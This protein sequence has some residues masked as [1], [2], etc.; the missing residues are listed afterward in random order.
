MLGELEAGHELHIFAGKQGPLK[1]VH[2]E[3]HRLNLLKQ[4]TF[5][6]PC[7]GLRSLH[8]AIQHP[9]AFA[10]SARYGR[11]CSLSRLLPALASCRELRNFDIIHAHFGTNGLKAVAL[12]ELG[13]TQGKIITTFYGQDVT[14]YPRK[15]GSDCYR[16]LFAQ[17]DWFLGISQHLVDLVCRLGCNPAKISKLHIGVQSTDFD[18]RPRTI[19]PGEP[20]RLLTVARLTEKKGLEYAIRAVARIKKQSPALEYRILGEGPLRGQLERL[21]RQLG[22]E[23][24]IQLSGAV[25]HDQVR[26]ACA[27][28][29]LFILPS[30]T[31]R[32]GDQ[33]GQALV[34]QEAQASGLPVLAT[35]HDGIPEGVLD[36]QS[37]FLVPER[38]VDALAERLSFLLTHPG[39]W[40]EMGKAGHRFVGEKFDNAQLTKCLLN[41]YHDLL[42][43]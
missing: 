6:P 1:S 32:N 3:I 23:K 20:I 21:V 5:P 33:E 4:T 17:G 24:H 22:M 25:P 13:I 43:H 8:A 14:H 28:A 38:D 15:H 12:R 10:I 11:A 30:V 37:G 26:T 29:H 36:G 35:R 19:G 9:G 27:H 42:G 40:P 39:L 31:A 34:L 2:P 7:L 16:E 18:F 41:T